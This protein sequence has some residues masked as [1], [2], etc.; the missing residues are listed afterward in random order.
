MVQVATPELNVVV[1]DEHV[2]A[3]PLIVQIRLPVGVPLPGALTLTVAV[4]T[5]LPLVETKL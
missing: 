3:P 2:L 1:D 4:N 5:R